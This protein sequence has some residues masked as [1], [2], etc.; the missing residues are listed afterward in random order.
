MQDLI[1]IGAS[2]AGCSAAI[3]SAR[4]NLKFSIISKDVGGEVNLSGQVNNW[5]GI[6]EINGFALAQTFRKH[7]ES[8]GI[9]F[10][11]GWEITKI[12][13]I[14]NYFSVTAKNFSGEEKTWEG[15]AVIVATGIHPRNLGI[16]GEKEFRG[17]GVT[18]CT[19]CDGPLYRGKTTL[20]IGAGNAA[21]ES[22]LMMSELTTKVYL[23]TKYPNTPEAKGGFPKGEDIM[24]EK[25]KALPN[26]EIIYN[27]ETQEIIGEQMVNEVKYK[28]LTTNEEK[29]V[30]V[31]GIMIH[32]GMIPNSNL[33]DVEKS[34]SGEII[35]DQKC[36]TNTPGIFAA[37]DVTNIPF[38]QIAIATG[39]GVTAALSAIGYVNKWKEE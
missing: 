27:A 23:L 26:V 15:K 22:A 16:P 32:I 7:V 24:V 12:E 4:R 20:T 38:K 17:K 31:Q 21:L 25:V 3:Y 18:Y 5:P 11:E 35:I 6:I 14:K 29:T 30:A 9:K 34:R 1:I 8:Y 13:K 36:Q 28:D 10:D 19:V 2:A 39:Q 33:I 37:G